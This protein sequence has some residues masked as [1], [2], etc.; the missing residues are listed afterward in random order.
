[1]LNPGQSVC[2]GCQSGL[3]RALSWTTDEPRASLAGQ[4]RPFRRGQTVTLRSGDD[5]LAGKLFLPKSN[6]RAPVLLICHGAGDWKENYFEMCEYL[7][8]NGVGAFA[9]DMHGH[10]QSEGERFCVNLRQWVA[11]V[12]AAIDFLLTH[13][14]VD[15]EKLA[16]FGLGSGAAAVLEA[17]LL[18]PR[19]KALIV[20]DAAVCNNLPPL[21]TL[22]LK[23]LLLLGRMQRC[24]TG[25]PLRLPLARFTTLRVASDP[26]VNRR[27]VSYAPS[28]E[29][30]MA[31]PLPGAEQALFVDTIQRVSRVTA[32]TLV[33]WGE[34]DQLISSEAGQA[35]FN[36]LTCEKRFEVI[37]G[38]GHL[39]HLD[40][41]RETVFNLTTDWVLQ[42]IA[43]DSV[44]THAV[45]SS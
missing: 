16:A 23:A 37:P 8:A 29:A 3:A 42:T 39:G 13:P 11:D 27:I 22:A 15:G 9:I 26:D 2:F 32:P 21:T 7:A 25:K 4:A 33:L 36:A 30:L 41:N 14:R 1:M 5:D 24:L 38:N 35:L 20:L 31:F 44:A 40:R 17:S 28:L 6:R 18:T 10:G 45:C 34:D 12:S 19:L 43:G